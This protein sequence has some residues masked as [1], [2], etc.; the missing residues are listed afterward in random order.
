M[1]CAGRPP[2]GVHE[3][4]Q[5]LQRC[6]VL[7]RPPGPGATPPPG[8]PVGAPLRFSDLSLHQEK[9]LHEV[10]PLR[11]G[12]EL[13]EIVVVRDHGLTGLSACS[14]LPHSRWGAPAAHPPEPTRPPPVRVPLSVIVPRPA[15]MVPVPLRPPPPAVPQLLFIAP[16][17]D[18]LSL[19]VPL[20][21]LE[22]R[23]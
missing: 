12:Q 17:K 23:A 5:T 19:V 1:R 9:D 20:R 13:I 10:L 22:G 16:S 4:G 8:L 11:R 21:P 18:P 3:E 15:P 2:A 14:M 6:R 7:Q